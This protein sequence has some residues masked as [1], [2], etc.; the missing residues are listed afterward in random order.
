MRGLEVL[1]LIPAR[2][3]S[4]SVPRKNLRQVGGRP[5]IAWSIEHA[6]R[7]SLIGRVVVTTDDQEIADIAR[8][9]GAEVPFLR[10]ADLAGDRSTDIEYHVHALEWLAREQ[11][12]RPD[13][14]VNL[15]PAMP[16]RRIATIDRAIATLAGRGDVD[17]LRSV[18]L[19]T[20]TPFKM[21]RIGPA[22]LLDPI[23]GLSGVAEPYNLPRQM[24]PP[25]Y[26]QDGYIDV[27]WSRVVL[28]QQSTTGRRILP[29]LIDEAYVDIDYEDAIIAAE[30]L[31]AAMNEPSPEASPS[32]ERYPS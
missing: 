28:Q 29:F 8:S 17:S 26:W 27:V 3:G 1:G 19:A 24:L 18:T 32:V 5:L 13:L 2:G 6:R 25:A 20:Q 12:Y 11:G 16:V 31:L 10:P 30:R 23:A 4:K 9:W 7:A 14:V 22:G 15:R 21:W